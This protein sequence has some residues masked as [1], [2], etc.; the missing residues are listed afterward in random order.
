[1]D[2]DNELAAEEEF[3]TEL[4]TAVEL[5]SGIHLNDSDDD[6]NENEN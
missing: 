5:K 1:M 3:I 2:N 4:K 6:E